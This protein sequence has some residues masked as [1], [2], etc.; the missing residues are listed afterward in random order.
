MSFSGDTIQSLIPTM[1]AG[2]MEFF[3]NQTHICPG[4]LGGLWALGYSV[5]PEAPASVTRLAHLVSP[6]PCL[7]VSGCLRT[8]CLS[9]DKNTL[10]LLCLALKKSH[11]FISFSKVISSL[12]PFCFETL[13]LDGSFQ[14]QCVLHC[15][16][17]RT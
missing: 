11:S 16:D 5:S 9:H 13:A 17:E 15:V 14:V 4:S 3:L 12:K 2:F 10:L 8:E 1:T 7:L 6:C